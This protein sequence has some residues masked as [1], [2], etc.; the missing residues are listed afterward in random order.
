MPV[1]SLQYVINVICF[2]CTLKACRPS[3][4]CNKGCH[5]IYGSF[6]IRCICTYI[7]KTLV[8]RINI[9]LGYIFMIA[10][11]RNIHVRLTKND[12]YELIFTWSILLNKVLFQEQCNILLDI[13]FCFLF[14]KVFLHHLSFLISVQFNESIRKSTESRKSQIAALSWRCMPYCV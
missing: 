8:A 14:P 3:K 10:E 5:I 1:D 6:K 12:V 9:R 13:C 4:I 7:S 11:L 2:L